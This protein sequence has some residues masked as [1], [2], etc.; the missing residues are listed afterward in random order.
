MS[1][2]YAKAHPCP[3]PLKEPFGTEAAAL[4]KVVRINA[5]IGNVREKLPMRAYRCACGAWHM[6]SRAHSYAEIAEMMSAAP[7][8]RV[9][10]YEAMPDQWRDVDSGAVTF[11]EEMPDA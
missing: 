6:T 2:R 8:P 5:E 7:A 10:A 1:R 11:A 4:E 3:T 9:L